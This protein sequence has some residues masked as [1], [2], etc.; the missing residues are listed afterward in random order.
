MAVFSVKDT[1]RG[2]PE[3]EKHLLFQKFARLS[4]RPTAGETSTGLGLSIAKGLVEAMNGR[5]YCESV[6]GRGS[7]FVVELLAADGS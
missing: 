4:P 5:I 3:Q 2:I 1:G 7:T 6:E